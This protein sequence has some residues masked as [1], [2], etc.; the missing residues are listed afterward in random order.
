[1]R[2]W[3]YVEDHCAAIGLIL[4][5]GR[6]GEVYNVGGNNEMRNI[7]VVRRI[8]AALDLPDSRIAHVAD[9]KGHDLRYAID[10]GKIRAELGWQP[11]TGFD[12]GIE[13]TIRWYL[14]NRSWWERILSGEYQRNLL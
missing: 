5:R 7:D 1:V 8:L 6:P 10:A 9:R 12:D 14:E 11:K 4:D 3:L 2:D 13:R